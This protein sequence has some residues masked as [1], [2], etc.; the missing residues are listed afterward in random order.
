MFD[1]QL[2]KEFPVGNSSVT[3]SDYIAQYATLCG[4]AARDEE[5]FKK[6]RSAK[7]MVE[8]LDHVSIEQ[9]NAYIS[10]ILKYGQWSS[11]YTK[12]I[13]E[14]DLLG[15]PRKF[16]F[17]HYGTFSPTL[18]R[19]LKV[20]LDLKNNF[21][22]VK[23]LNIVEIGIGFGGQSSLISLLDNPASY[24]FY[25]IPPVIELAR[26]F[27]SQLNLQG[28]F[29]FFD[30]RN[31]VQSKPDL[32]I[33]NYAFSELSRGVQDI[34]LKNV[35]LHSQRGYITWNSSSIYNSGA[36]SLADLVRLIPNSQIIPELP[37]TAA[38]NAIII[39]GNKNQ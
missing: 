1:T 15:K 33:S 26:K 17:S 14:I 37:N 28:E 11:Q 30:G 29:K 12:V 16:K 21:G 10:Q 35:I 38:E 27:I 24:T 32:V 23:N 19:Y 18:L 8:A 25:D 7:V 22:E 20:Y 4:S 39:W 34:Y 5:V 13:R 31:P 2:S 9:G 3:D 36:Y 6:F